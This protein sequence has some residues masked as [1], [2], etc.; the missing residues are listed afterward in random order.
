MRTGSVVG[1]SLV[2]ISAVIAIA[3]N[4]QMSGGLSSNAPQTDQVADADGNLHVPDSYRRQ[5]TPDV[6]VL[7]TPY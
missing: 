7:Y 4:A 6:R 1:I 2:G 3:A 5:E